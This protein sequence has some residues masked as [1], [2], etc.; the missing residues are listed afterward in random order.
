MGKVFADITMSLDGFIAGPKPSLK[1]PL[2]KGGEQ[3]HEWAYR[4]AAWRKPHGL[5]GGEAGPDGDVMQ[6][7]LANTGAV[8]MGRKMFSNGKGPWQDDPKADGWWGDN[9]PFHVPVFILT[10][11]SRET[12]QKRGGNSFTFV[13]DGIE[14]ALSQAKAAAKDKDISI[15]GGAN[16]IQQ[17]IKAGL[18][19]ELQIHVVPQL[20][21]GGTPLLVNLGD[22]KLEKI[23]LIDSPLVTHIKFKIKK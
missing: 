20:L 23:R 19:D 17:F 13:T 6:E 1:D 2:G 8:I 16:A 3:L 7:T 18:L 22:T 11:H 21:G 15:A 5:P 12:V 4:L 9:P 14:S 10:H